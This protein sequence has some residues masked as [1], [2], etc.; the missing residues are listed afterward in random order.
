MM[1]EKVRRREG[2]QGV[3][4]VPVKDGRIVWVV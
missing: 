1:L 3:R 2:D 4:A